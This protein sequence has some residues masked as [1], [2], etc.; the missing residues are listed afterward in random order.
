[1]YTL[2]LVYHIGFNE[3]AKYRETLSIT[4]FQNIWEDGSSFPPPWKPHCMGPD[5]LKWL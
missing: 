4:A 2:I 3:L 5:H 1:M